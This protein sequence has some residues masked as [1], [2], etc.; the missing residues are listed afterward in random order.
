MSRLETHLDADDRV[1]LERDVRDSK[2]IR[3]ALNL[4]W[5]PVTPVQAAEGPF[6][7]GAPARSRGARILPRRQGPA[8]APH[9]RA[10]HGGGRSTAR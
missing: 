4:C 1:E 2:T 3:I 10:L 7:Q 6:L 8:V 5:L 9:H